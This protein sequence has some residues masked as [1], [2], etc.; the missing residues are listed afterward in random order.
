MVLATNFIGHIK[1]L[2]HHTWICCTHGGGKGQ[3]P[4]FTPHCQQPWPHC[5][6]S[7]IV[8]LGVMTWQ[9]KYGWML[10]NIPASSIYWT[11]LLYP[12]EAFGGAAGRMQLWG[13]LVRHAKTRSKTWIPGLFS[14]HKSQD[15][16]KITD[17]YGAFIIHKEQSKVL[18]AFT[19]LKKPIQIDLPKGVAGRTNTT[20]HF[21]TNQQ[22]VLWNAASRS[23]P[24]S[25]WMN[26]HPQAL[27]PTFNSKVQSWVENLFGK[28]LRL[29][30]IS[31]PTFG[32]ESSSKPRFQAMF[33][34]PPSFTSPRILCP[35]WRPKASA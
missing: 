31:S 4:N 33:G 17:W 23:W 11:L 29:W 35:D 32:T 21:S 22:H 14:H 30:V 6:T 25:V 16:G 24:S 7:Q 28:L 8:S 5:L 27:D 19:Y 3:L 26:R 34:L 15:L 9:A 2:G 12:T 18:F 10:A 20:P 13:P 1:N